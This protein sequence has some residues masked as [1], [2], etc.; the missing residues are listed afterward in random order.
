MKLIS[1]LYP[2]LPG[3]FRY[4]LEKLGR[5]LCFERSRFYELC[6]STLAAPDFDIIRKTSSRLMADLSCSSNPVE[7]SSSYNRSILE[8]MHKVLSVMSKNSIDPDHLLDLLPQF[9]QRKAHAIIIELAKERE[10][11]NT[12]EHLKQKKGENPINATL[13]QRNRPNTFIP[14]NPTDQPESEESQTNLTQA[15]SK[16]KTINDEKKAR[17]T[18]LQHHTGN[19]REI[20]IPNSAAATKRVCK[21]APRTNTDAVDLFLKQVKHDVYKPRAERL[22]GKIKAHV[23]EYFMC[24]LCNTHAKEVRAHHVCFSL[25][26]S[27]HQLS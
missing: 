21:S 20:S 27:T 11:A 10:I 25:L 5:K 16:G 9:Y 22:N 8:S 13:F 1:L 6:K 17:V 18:T 19:K 12:K 23:P 4:S 24:S 2:L 15:L 26:N 3:K 14:A 7:D